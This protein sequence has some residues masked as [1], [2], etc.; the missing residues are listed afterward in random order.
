MCEG[1]GHCAVPR[2]A[3]SVPHLRPPPPSNPAQVVKRLS[4]WQQQVEAE[5]GRPAGC[6]VLLMPAV[7]D[8][9]HAAVY[10]QPPFDLPASSKVGRGR[11]AGPDCTVLQEWEA[12][13]G[14]SV[15]H[16]SRPHARHHVDVE[17]VLAPY[18]AYWAC[19]G[20]LWSSRIFS[21]CNNSP[22]TCLPLPPPACP[23]HHLPALPP[24]LARPP[25]LPP[26]PPA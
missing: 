15:L 3:L 5:P 9:T 22:T 18:G 1:R 7:R 16:T 2:T 12:W 26:F 23:P 14:S 19:M 17:E 20:C 8:A 6:Q 10:P 24:R 11:G 25:C 13:H 4:A 21:S